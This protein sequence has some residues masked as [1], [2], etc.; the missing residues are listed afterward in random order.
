VAQGYRAFLLGA[1]FRPVFVALFRRACSGPHH[2]WGYS[3]YQSE[4]AD[5]REQERHCVSLRWWRHAGQMPAVFEG[6]PRMPTV[7]SPE[8]T[9]SWRPAA[10]RAAN[11]RA[12]VVAR[13]VE[14]PVDYRGGGAHLRIL[15]STLRRQCGSRLFFASMTHW[16]FRTT[17]TMLDSAGWTRAPSAFK[18]MRLRKKRTSASLTSMENH[19]VSLRQGRSSTVIALLESAFLTQGSMLE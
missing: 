2:R 5:H 19:K 7:A 15:C 3:A 18:S 12:G 11:A 4:C 17:A 1:R 8:V 10:E 16:S 13:L 9:V 14:S 6:V